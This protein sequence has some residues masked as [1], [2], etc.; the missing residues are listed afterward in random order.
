MVV[1]A[2]TATLALTWWLPAYRLS[3]ARAAWQPPPDAVI[4]SPM[5]E[6]PVPGWRISVAD[7]GLPR[8]TDSRIAVGNRPVD[9]RPF[10]GS[11]EERAYFLA[12]S[13]VGDERHW[14][15]TGVDVHSGQPLF[16]A[17]SLG[18]GRQVPECFLNGPTHILCLDGGIADSAWVIDGRSGSVDYSGP[19]DLQSNFGVLSVHQVGIHA[20]ATQQDEGVYGIG[21]QAET[22]W[23]VPGNGL[24]KTVDRARP[25]ASSQTLTAQLEANPR[26]YISTVFSVVDGKVIEPEIDEASHLGETSFYT[27][28]F[29][30]E[31]VE[32]NGLSSEIAFFDE[33]GKRL[34]EYEG[35]GNPGNSPADLPVIGPNS[36]GRN[37]VF[38]IHGQPLIEVPGGTLHLVGTTL[39]VDGGN[40]LAFPE[41]QLYNMRDGT[42][43]GP[44]C[45]YP[46]HH[47]LG[48]DG[49]TLVFEVTN[50]NAELLAKAHDLHSCER[51]WTLPKKPDSLDRIWN[52][53][54]TLVQLADEG[55]ELTSL[56]APN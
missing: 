26:T 19:T 40:S 56:V 51:L 14:W 15:L 49:S 23:F 10:I 24:L 29:A 43:A 8:T 17:V 5:R 50:R 7:L 20:V 22:T 41:L 33:T 27:G 3:S 16:A 32:P 25:G 31:V 36:D 45:D 6:P 1:V 53:D 48:T 39:M 54:G 42:A 13:G 52:I 28:G 21:P 47:Y 46:M 55:T 38:T 9:P 12:D 18:A 37:T 2:V 44:V 34:G 30:A 11:I 4:S 35:P